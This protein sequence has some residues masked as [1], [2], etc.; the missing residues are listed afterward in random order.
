MK[1]REPLGVADVS[2]KRPQTKTANLF[3]RTK[4]SEVPILALKEIVLCFLLMRNLTP[5]Q[6]QTMH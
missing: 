2:V 6:T 4:G 1:T 3:T 5:C